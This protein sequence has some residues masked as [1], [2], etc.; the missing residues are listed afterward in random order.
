M[1]QIVNKICTKTYK[2]CEFCSD[3][4][5]EFDVKN[6]TMLTSYYCY[7]CFFGV[8]THIDSFPV[9]IYSKFDEKNKCNDCD[10]LGINKLYFLKLEKKL[11]LCDSHLCPSAPMISTK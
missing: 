3:N 8:N 4:K 10:S 9:I 2:Q 1:S 5:T 7:E 11:Y 6:D